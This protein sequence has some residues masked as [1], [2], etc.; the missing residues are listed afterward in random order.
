MIRVLIVDDA[1][2][3]RLA[4][5]NVLSKNGFMVVDDAKNG[6]EAID[7]YMEQ[8][9]DIVTMDITMPDMTG[10]EAL[11]GIRAFDPSAKV[12]MISAMG[13]ESMVKEAIINGAKSFI[14]KPFREEHIIQT[15]VKVSAGH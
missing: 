11:K 7:K 3:M 10:I 9:P 8:R 4:I 15:L 12:V 14:V 1:A 6:Q 2:F 13:Q 5:R